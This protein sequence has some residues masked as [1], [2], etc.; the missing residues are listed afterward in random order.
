MVPPI[1]SSTTLMVELSEEEIRTR[2]L[3]WFSQVPHRVK[4]N[5]PGHLVV[6]TGSE[7]RLRVWGGWHI[8]STSLPAR[9]EVAIELQPRAHNAV[10]ITSTTRTVGIKTG[11]KG[12]YKARFDEIVNGVASSLTTEG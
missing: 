7:L 6:E 8:A 1:V 11:I 10:T 5:N 4:S 9:T 2:A 12:K 3:A